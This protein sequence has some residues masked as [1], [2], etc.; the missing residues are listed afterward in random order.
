M[1]QTHISIPEYDERGLT[2]EE[3]FRIA[4]IMTKHE[5]IY[6][7]E[8]HPSECICDLEAYPLQIIERIVRTAYTLYS[9]IE[10]DKDYVVAN[11]IV[12]SLADSISSFILIYNEKDSNMRALRHYLYIMDGLNGRLKQL[13]DNLMNN[14]RLCESEFDS[15]V[16]QIKEAKNNYES[17]FNFSANQIRSLIIYHDRKSIVDK[18]IKISNWKFKNLNSATASYKWNE[19]YSFME[20]NSS[21]FFSLL[22]E[23]VHGFSTS[24]FAYEEDQVTFEPIYGLATSLM[25]KLRKIIETIYKNDIIRIR[26]K[27]ITALVDHGMPSQYVTNLFNALLEHNN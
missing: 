25:G 10:R 1:N 21:S 13:P 23:F 2:Y 22:S 16:K 14:G 18:L 6:L 7:K 24:N 4:L 9:V 26:P 11:M 15:L 27:M 19:L 17:A 5:L 12:R 3:V 20:L 8:L